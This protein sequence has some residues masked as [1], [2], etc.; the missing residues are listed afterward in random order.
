M[1][2]N[3]FYISPELI[4]AAG[5]I[6]VLVAGLGARRWTTPER[7]GILSPEVLSVVVLL[8]ALMP[9]LILIMPTPDV[10]I[11]QFGGT[12]AVDRFAAF[13]KI[14]AI[15]STAIVA[16]LA[17]DYFRRIKF[18][19]GEFYALLV[20][21]TLAITSLAASTDLI[22][23]YL[24]L[25][26]LSITSY[27]LAGYLKQDPRSNEAAVKYF[28]YGSIAAAVMIYG[29]SMLY[30]VTGTTNIL[31]IANKLR[32]GHADPALYPLLYLASLFILVGFGFKISMVPFHQWAPD[33]YEGAPTP[34]TAFLSVG[35]KA[36]GFAVLVRVLYTAL[37][38]LVFDWTPLIIV[39]SGLTMTVGNLVA[40]PQLNIKRMLAYSSIAQAGYI[41]LGVAAMGVAA[42]QIKS[43]AIQAVLIYIFVYLFMNLGAF[44]VVTMLS[45]RLG[46]DEIRNFAGLIKRSPFAAVAMVFFLLSLAGIP[47]TAGFLGKFYLFAAAVQTGDAAVFWLTIVAIANTV[48]SVYYYMNVVRYMFFV[49]PM[50]SEP[51]TASR[52]LNFVIGLTLAMTLIV[53][54]YPQPFIEMARISSVF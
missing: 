41:L 4:L 3:L 22:M 12:F 45:A 7:L 19:R 10:G 27:V 11:S 2:F 31:A 47:P 33:T 34:I 32:T 29:M 48:V 50:Q 28:L 1:N 26:F 25:E 52:P 23:I 5:G 13:F 54:L 16:L 18:H 17:I 53:L 24:S 30:G 14:I 35:S 36:A 8:A 38:P 49:E 20:F 42:P 6:V 9:S 21:V 44:A 39:L 46:S 15:V 40:I 37:P 43:S 51:I